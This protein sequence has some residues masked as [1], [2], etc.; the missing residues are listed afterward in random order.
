MDRDA[1][2]MWVV[3][4]HP[5]DHPDAYVA[6]RWTAVRGQPLATGDIIKSPDLEWVRRGVRGHLELAGI[7]PVRLDRQT[8]DE[9]QI[10]EVWL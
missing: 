5:R 9:P 4:D 6:R 10:L 3:Y 8:N 2:Q 7:S 1:F